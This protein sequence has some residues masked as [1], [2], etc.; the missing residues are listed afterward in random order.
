MPPTEAG[1]FSPSV[2]EELLRRAI[3]PSPAARRIPR[4]YALWTKNVNTSFSNF[5]A[6]SAADLRSLIGWRERIQEPQ[7]GK[8]GLG[9]GR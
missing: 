8:Q 1:G 7:I 6:A 3:A 9:D 4:L 5:S 2:S